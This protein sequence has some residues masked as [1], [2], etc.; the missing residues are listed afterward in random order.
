MTSRIKAP[1]K[2]LYNNDT[3]NTTGVVSPWREQGEAFSEEMLVGVP[4]GYDRYVYEGGENQDRGD[5]QTTGTNDKHHQP[6]VGKEQREEGVSS[7]ASALEGH[8]T[9]E[10]ARGEALH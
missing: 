4:N 10:E 2:L 5:G 9:G 1:F 8:G 7:Q 6:G 3:T